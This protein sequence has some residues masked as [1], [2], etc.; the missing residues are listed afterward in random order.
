M[1]H[2]GE[3]ARSF[4]VQP[5]RLGNDAL[6]YVGGVAEARVFLAEQTSRPG[7]GDQSSVDIELDEILAAYFTSKVNDLEP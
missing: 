3:F 5:N 2:V 1:N 6:Q 4:K 7:E